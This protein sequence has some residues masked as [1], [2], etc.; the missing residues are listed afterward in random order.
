MNAA[1][2]KAQP[3]TCPVL[4]MRPQIREAES[5]SGYG[6]R[7]RE[8][9][10]LGG[11]LLS[12]GLLGLSHRAFLS[13]PPNELQ[14]A[15][16]SRAAWRAL[17]ESRTEQRPFASV[18]ATCSS[19]LT[20]V[21]PECL[22]E[23]EYLRAR[24]EQPLHVHC[25]RHEALLLT[26][27]P[28]CAALLRSAGHSVLQCACRFDLREAAA[29][30]APP[31]VRRW[32]RTLQEEGLDGPQIPQGVQVEVVSA[33]RFV[34]RLCASKKAVRPCDSQLRLLQADE[35]VAFARELD[36]YRQD[37]RA[38]F[39]ELLVRVSTH[40]ADHALNRFA[41]SKVPLL[42]LIAQQRRFQAADA[43]DSSRCRAHAGVI[44]VS[45]GEFADRT[46]F[47]HA[48]VAGLLRDGRIKGARSFGKNI[49]GNKRWIPLGE[50][51]VWQ[52]LVAG[53]FTFEEVRQ[54]VGCC[55]RHLHVMANLGVLPPIRIQP[56]TLRFRIEEVLSFRARVLARTVP[57]NDRDDELIVL[58]HV[59]VRDRLGRY[60]PELHEFWRGVI[61]REIHLY[62]DASDEHVI[63]KL[64]VAL[65]DLPTKLRN[66]WRR[67]NRHR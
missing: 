40:E 26:H 14:T 44:Y 48:T 20:R 15:L 60:S 32:S 16:G 52:S 42:E 54:F 50:C 23:D 11:T 34:L 39:R 6:V 12:K 47:R 35:A 66:T 8:R 49:Q 27:C 61:A 38:L 5:H 36:N 3:D 33:M 67:R 18:V 25:A 46:A 2:S 31:E 65:A 37:L 51:R 57:T 43:P 1:I 28:R 24:W 53:T 19:T 56:S 55:S 63:P 58:W 21:C 17:L 62:G 30:F 45:V 7:L 10:G 22:R 41:R 4:L 64:R 13:V 29:L 59:P 9:N